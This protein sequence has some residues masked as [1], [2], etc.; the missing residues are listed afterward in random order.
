MNKQILTQ[1]KL[2]E[3]FLYNKE[4][5]LLSNKTN[6][7]RAKKGQE[8]GY[9]SSHGYRQVE[10]QGKAYMYHHVCWAIHH[11]E[12]PKAQLDHINHNRADNRVI[13]LRAVTNQE[14][15]KNLSKK[16]NNTSGYTGISNFYGDKFIVRIT[17]MGKTF[18]LGSYIDI[19][20]A[21]AVR[22]RA[23][24]DMGFHTNHGK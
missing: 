7:G 16:K 5:G 23:Y 22:D 3:T 13:K 14:N 2:N 12:W 24:K 8:A 20:E 1:D 10:V 15:S 21:I 17:S 4:T 19:N 11:G 9:D 6:R 18:N